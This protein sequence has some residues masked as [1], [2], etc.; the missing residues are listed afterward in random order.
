VGQCKVLEKSPRH[1]SLPDKSAFRIMKLK[2]VEA[3]TLSHLQ[4]QLQKGI[5]V[6]PNMNFNAYS[7]SSTGIHSLNGLNIDVN[8]EG[9]YTVFTPPYFLTQIEDQSLSPSKSMNIKRGTLQQFI[10]NAEEQTCCQA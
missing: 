10:D 4:I 5:I 7:F 9:A 6:V 8:I 2:G 1:V 3:I